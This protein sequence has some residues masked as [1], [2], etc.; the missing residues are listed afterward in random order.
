M[1]KLPQSMRLTP[2]VDNLELKW[3]TVEGGRSKASVQIVEKLLNN[4][5]AVHGGAIYTMADACMGAASFF[6][7]GE[8]ELCKTIEM[9][10]NYFKPAIEGELVCEARVI[11]QS[12]NLSTVE[13]EVTNNGRLIAKALGT[14]FIQKIGPKDTIREEK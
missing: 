1:R 2:F 9:K 4:Y 3:H 6:A 10:I 13:G 7:L 8:D 11:N 5:G 12:N 14:F